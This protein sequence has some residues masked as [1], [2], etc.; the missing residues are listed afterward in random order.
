M[1]I[2]NTFLLSFLS[3]I[4]FSQSSLSLEDAIN[5]AIQHNLQIVIVRNEATMAGMNNSWSNAGAFPT[6]QGSITP[7][8][9]SNNLNQKLASGLDINRNNV[10]SR[11]FN[12]EIS[13]N[14]NVLNGFKLYTTKSKLEELQSMGELAVTQ[15]INAISFEVAN[16]YTKAQ[17]ILQQQKNLDEQ[18]SIT[19]ERIKVAR[20]KFDVGAS[21]KNDL[22][23]AQIDKNNLLNTKEALNNEYTN[24][25]I[26]LGLLLGRD[27]NNPVSVSD[28][29]LLQPLGALEALTQSA[30]KQNP[31]LLL[32]RKQ[33]NV[34]SLSQKEIRAEV[35]PNLNIR[36]AY[37]YNRNQS[38]GG[39]SLFNQNYGPSASMSIGIPIYS[40]GRVRN[41]LDILDLQIKNQNLQ[42]QQLELEYKTYISQAYNEMTSAIDRIE[43][44][45]QNYKLAQENLEIALGRA[46]LQS[47]T[48]IELREAQFALM[49]IQ[50]KLTDSVYA[51]KTGQNRITLL[52]GGSDW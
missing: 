20:K 7:S 14:W 51:A 41:Q 4:G 26:S 6:V 44:S 28:S 33:I 47:I 35:L 13:A 48:G 19:D 11:N 2:C 17:W 46:R 10:F 27:I 3:L 16:T 1:K 38:D 36:T 52:T 9:S 31:E 49:D 22:L 40:G 50:S 32:A 12:A 30:L 21:G 8:V 34:L 5:E 29:I 18:I 23:Q 24:L 39:F 15:K 43:L 42:Q 25:I 45:R 37:G